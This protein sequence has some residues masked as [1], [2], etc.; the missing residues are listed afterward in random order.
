M[1]SSFLE[2]LTKNL[3]RKPWCTDIK[4]TKLLVRPKEIAINYNYIQLNS[5]YYQKYLILDLDYE[6]SLAEILFSR[7]GIPLPNFVTANFQGGR[8]HIVFELEEPIYKTNA[9]K[10]KIIA[11]AQAIIIRLQE[12][13]DADLGY[14]GTL[15][16]NPASPN[17]RVTELRKKPYSLY[18]L[19][20]K[21]D[22]P[23][24]DY[25]KRKISADE[26]IGLGRNCYVFYTACP[27][28]Y[29]E[30]R[31]YRG[32]TYRQWEMAMINHCVSLNE[33]LSEPMTYREVLCIAK[34]ISR[35]CWKNDAYC[36]QEF[37]DRQ[38][39]KGAIGGK[40]S[41]RTAKIDSDRSTK[42]WEELG[43][44][45]KTYYRDRKKINENNSQR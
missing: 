36:Y 9:S 19:A 8:S 38:R 21:I 23:R 31:A 18:E 10:Q 39:R 35:F 44:S 28:A 42:P 4:G 20:E 5:P 34:S 7:V 25:S 3:P 13:F 6:H 30:I 1:N 22:L 15:T 41:K 43:I 12:L 26:A 45:R 24:K 16:K 40:K 17:W 11:F 32:K 29:Q 27:F 37:I 2:H 14:S 33:N